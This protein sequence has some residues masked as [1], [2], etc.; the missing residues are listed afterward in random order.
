[1][2]LKQSI[3]RNKYPV[4]GSYYYCCCICFVFS[5][6]ALFLTKGHLP[7]LLSL[8]RL[9]QSEYGISSSICLKSFQLTEW[10]SI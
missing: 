7:Q 9:A 1:M 6:L 4:I 10:G 5:S 8:C 3:S 2:F